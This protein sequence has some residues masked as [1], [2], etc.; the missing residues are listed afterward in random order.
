MRYRVEYETYTSKLA[1][2]ASLLKSSIWVGL[3]VFLVIFNIPSFICLACGV[4]GAG[5]IFAIMSGVAVISL[6]LF[7]IFVKP[8]KI[9]DYMSRRSSKQT[10]ISDSEHFIFSLFDTAAKNSPKDLWSIEFILYALFKTRVVLIYSITANQP[11]EK[12][13]HDLVYAFDTLSFTCLKRYNNMPPAKLQV[14]Y[15]TRIGAYD[16]IYSQHENNAFVMSLITDCLKWFLY[17]CAICLPNGGRPAVPYGTYYV[18]EKVPDAVFT[19]EELKQIDEL[20]IQTLNFLEKNLDNF[21]LSLT[22]N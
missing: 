9:D 2:F 10:A 13:Q 17:N 11:N 5:I 20:D 22:K 18:P 21:I 8:E 14:F 15:Q 4:D 6:I 16:S 1:T 12:K 7:C 19:K 3:S